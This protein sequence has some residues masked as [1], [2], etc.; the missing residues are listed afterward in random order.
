MEHISS[1]AQRLT[2][3]KALEVFGEDAT[4]VLSEKLGSLNKK[5]KLKT[6]VQIAQEEVANLDFSLF[7][8]RHN[9]P[10]SQTDLV[11]V[12]FYS[13]KYPE[14]ESRKDEIKKLRREKRRIKFA[15]DMA[16]GEDEGKLD[17]ESAK[18]YPIE[19]IIEVTGKGRVKSAFCPFHSETRPS[20][21]VYTH[22]N[23]FYCFSCKEHGDV[24][25]L[26]MK[27]KGLKFKEAVRYLS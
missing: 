24:I 21:K 4:S 12:L 22:D 8:K 27:L 17:I 1:I 6:S 5:I 16:K 9:V 19:H 13:L 15:L 3:K 20:F 11:E 23:S 26:V 25:D 14:L 18:E 10:L 2:T 7:V